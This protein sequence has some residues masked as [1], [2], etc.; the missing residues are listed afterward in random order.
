MMMYFIRNEYDILAGFGAPWRVR[1]LSFWANTPCKTLRS[2]NGGSP[3]LDQVAEL[4]RVS[5]GPDGHRVVAKCSPCAAQAKVSR[6]RHVSAPLFPSITC[7]CSFTFDIRFCF[8][9][10]VPLIRSLLIGRRGMACTALAGR[11]PA[12]AP[13]AQLAAGPSGAAQSGRASLPR[14]RLLPQLISGQCPRCRAPGHNRLLSANTTPPAC[15]PPGCGAAVAD[16]AVQAVAVIA[17]A[18]TTASAEAFGPRLDPSIAVAA[19]AAA[20]PPVIFWA[21]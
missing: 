1:A 18:G 16:V 5:V 8:R 2:V 15:L 9:S 7:E 21:R 11:A 12:H 6:L 10:G 19:L 17:E 13:R 20:A 14:S 4:E 3:V